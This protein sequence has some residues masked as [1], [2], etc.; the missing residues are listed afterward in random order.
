METSMPIGGPTGGG[1]VSTHGPGPEVATEP[2]RLRYQPALDGVRA[3]AILAVLASHMFITLDSGGEGVDVFFVLSGFLITTLL[4]Q[5]HDSTGHISLR[6]FWWRRAARLLPALF[7]M[8]PIVAVAFAIVRP[9]EWRTSD[10]GVVS[11]LLY[12]SSWVRASGASELG[13]MGHTWSLSVEEWFYAAWPLCM[14]VLLRRG[15]RVAGWIVAAACLAVTYRLVSEHSG[16][17]YEYLYN[18]PDQ[19]AGQLLIGCAAGAG[20][21]ALGAQGGRYARAFVAGGVI[22]AVVVGA[23]LSGLTAEHAR[24]G[25]DYTSGQST[26][27]A[28]GAAAMILSIVAVPGWLL[29]R[30]LA[31]RPLVWIGRRSYGLY[32]WHLPIFGLVLLGHRAVSGTRLDAERVLALGLA[33]AAAAISFRYVERPAIRWVRNREAEKRRAYEVAAPVPAQA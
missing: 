32:L 1:T 25:F 30:T 19:R 14:I 12:T 28:L 29:A 21:F 23:T 13:W 4:L 11:A 20:L 6:A 15:S 22:G 10:L 33:F 5:E 31:W 2:N 24:Y 7:V 26:V 27:I 9:E 16:V 17:S 3:I 8:A 18:A